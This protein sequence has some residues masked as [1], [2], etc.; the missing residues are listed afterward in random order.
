MNVRAT[1]RINSNTAMKFDDIH[2][3]HEAGLITDEQR[4]QIIFHFGLKEQASRFLVIISFIGAVL[5]VA[6]FALLISANWNEIPAAVKI[7][8]GLA[9]MLG[10]HGTGWWLREKQ[11]I[12]PKTGEALYFIGSAL[13][14][15]NIALTGQI[16]HLESRAPNAFLLW[17]L[18]IM[19]LPWLLCS[20]AQFVL[21]LTALSVWFGCE[22]NASDSWLYFSNQYQILAYALLGL[23]FLGA[24]YWLRRTRFDGFAPVAEKLG[25]LGLLLFGYPLTWAGILSWS[26]SE[27]EFS[28]W[29]LPLLAATGTLSIV[30]GVRNVS[31]LTRQWRMTWAGSLAAAAGLILLAYYVPRNQGWHWGGHFDAVNAVAS[32]ALFILCLLQIQVALQERSRILVNLGVAVIG[33]DLI[34]AYFGLFGTM[35]FTGMM[36]LLTGVFLILF[37]V[38]LESQ[39]RQ[40][41]QQIKSSPAKEVV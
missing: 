41:M 26:R 7:T 36:F 15:A 38:Y 37:G 2:R 39:R 25:L 24:G 13:F 31:S 5:I 16:Y 20:K 22:L 17:L 19:A 6:G 34:S 8:T 18:G 32:I 33:L 23:N 11:K 30:S 1:P 4:D 40:L 3:I 14:L 9:L 10:A 35:A 29:L 28:W 21:F 27:S 12:H